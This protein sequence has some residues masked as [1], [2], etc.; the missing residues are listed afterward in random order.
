MTTL[1]FYSVKLTKHSLL[2][3]LKARQVNG[4]PR[5]PLK[6][7]V[8]KLKDE[9]KPLAKFQSR[10]PTSVEFAQS[11]IHSLSDSVSLLRAL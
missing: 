2:L 11:P 6:P 4:A 3:S 7:A 9:Q 1:L 5:T 8:P 10:A